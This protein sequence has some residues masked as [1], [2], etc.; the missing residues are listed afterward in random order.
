[1]RIGSGRVG[2]EIIR[3]RAVFDGAP[4]RSP[5]YGTKARRLGHG[6]IAIR[7]AFHSSVI[8]IRLSKLTALLA[9]LAAVPLV[10]IAPARAGDAAVPSLAAVPA[11]TAGSAA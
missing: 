8:M 1:M 10:L 4:L 7:F 11:I 2:P 9:C 5:R 6:T 3:L